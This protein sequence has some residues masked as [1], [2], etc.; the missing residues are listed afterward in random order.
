M[1]DMFEGYKLSTVGKLF[2]VGAGAWLI[3][4]SSNLKL[5]GTKQELDAVTEALLASK[6]FQ[7][8]LG[9]PGATVESVME[10]LDIKNMRADE[11]EQLLG[12]PWPF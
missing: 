6:R 7:N 2:L 4:K 8:E 3:G 5:R 12:I 11:F 1:S 10:K 9:K